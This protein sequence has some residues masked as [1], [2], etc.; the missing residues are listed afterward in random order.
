MIRRKNEVGGHNYLLSMLRNRPVDG[1]VT[2]ATD[3]ASALLLDPMTG[4]IGA[5]AL[6]KN[7]TG[8]VDVKVQLAAGQSL[9]LKTFDRPIAADPWRYITKQGTP[10]SIARGWSIAFPES[11]P[12]IEQRFVTDTLCDWTQLPDSRA[13]INQAT[14]RYE[15]CFTL[16]DPA[17]ADDWRL[18]LGDVRESAVVWINGQRVATLTTIPFTIEVGRYLQKGENRLQIDVTNLP[19]N[20]IAEMERQGVQWRIFKD[21]NIASV[22]GQKLFSFGD[23]PTDP[24]GLN[25]QVTLTP[26]YYE[27][28]NNQ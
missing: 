18:D 6:R 1:W 15:V 17:K 16:D 12:A 24:S 5:A 7:N 26:V 11:A 27:N 28:P 21:A 3:A 19:S 14:A 13:R 9:L 8:T 20:R 22:T 2:L 10:I 4:T 23:W 25:S